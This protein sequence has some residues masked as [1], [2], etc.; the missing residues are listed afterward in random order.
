MLV[1][2]CS[3][4]VVNLDSYDSLVSVTPEGTKY[5]NGKESFCES[6]LEQFGGWWVEG[7]GWWVVVDGGGGGVVAYAAPLRRTCWARR[8]SHEAEASGTRTERRRVKAR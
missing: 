8:S 5:L 2:I 4:Y 7:G 1:G 3:Y 6:I